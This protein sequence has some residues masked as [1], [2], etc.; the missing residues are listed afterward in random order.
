MKTVTIII[1]IALT[2]C[3]TPRATF[4][5]GTL[6]ASP[7]IVATY[8]KEAAKETYTIDTTAHNWWSRVQ[9]ISGRM[10]DRLAGMVSKTT[11]TV[12]E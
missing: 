5:G 2:G 8:A 3:A 4:Q 1:L 9:D 11:A 10:M 7:G 6:K 12:G